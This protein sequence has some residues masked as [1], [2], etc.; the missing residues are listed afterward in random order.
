VETSRVFARCVAKIDSDWLEALGGELCRRSHLHPHWE[1]NR[2]EVVALEQ[3]SLFGL[4]IVADRKVSY[5]RINPDEACDLFIRGALIEG[6]VKKPYKFMQH[7]QQLIDELLDLEDRVRRRDVLIG[8]EE[9]VAF[10]KERVDGITNLKDLSKFLKKRGRDDFLRMRKEN[11]IAHYPR[12]S[13]LFLYPPQI[14]LGNRIFDCDYR[15]EPGRADDGLTVK[16][17]AILAG[18]V[19]SEALDWLAPGLQQEKIATLIKSLPKVYRK[20]LVPV[21][22]TVAVITREMKT[23]GAA[24]IVE[25]GKFIYQRFGVDIPASAWPLD[26][27]PDYLKMRVSVIAPDGS[28]IIAGRDPAILKQHADA[29]AGSAGF[30]AARKKWEKTGLTRWDFGDLPDDVSDD[31]TSKV[32]WVA[33]PALDTSSGSDQSVDL[34]LFRQRDAALAAHRRGVATLYRIHFSRDLKFLKKYLMLPDRATPQVKYFGGARQFEKCLHAKVVDGL[35][36]KNIR[37]EGEFYAYAESVAPKIIPGG[38]KLLEQVLPLI[39]VY[40]ETA[41]QF[42]ALAFGKRCR[43]LDF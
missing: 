20:Q 39:D 13:E 28:E 33:Y 8:Q 2:G 43:C 1:R 25:L 6:D 4:I 29:G 16:V 15:F 7:N 41:Q 10:Y 24:F 3:V 38:Q 23:S 11:L 14:E 34:R 22:D 35:F 26:A 18:Q 37:S 40:H 31:G 32:R 9:M 30:E 42:A 27:L 19:P 36:S 5:G 12:E 17:P 21:K